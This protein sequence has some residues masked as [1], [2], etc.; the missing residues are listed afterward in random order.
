[1]QRLII[2]LMERD[3]TLRDAAARL[4]GEKQC[5]FHHLFQL[6]FDKLL[7]HFLPFRV[8]LQVFCGCDGS[9]RDL[10]VA[11]TFSIGTKV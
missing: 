10:S 6:L 3:A 4:K 1:M 8:S 2:F 9:E 5:Q 11:T 7:V